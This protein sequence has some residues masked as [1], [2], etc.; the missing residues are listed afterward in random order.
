M[1]TH[2]EMDAGGGSRGAEITAAVTQREHS[3]Q[4]ESLECSDWTGPFCNPLEESSWP[5]DLS[6]F[7][8]FIMGIQRAPVT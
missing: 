2:T 5:R 6:V 4:L 3:G 1:H 8:L 7:L